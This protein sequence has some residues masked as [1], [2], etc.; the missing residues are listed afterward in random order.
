[1]DAYN[2]IS[3]LGIFVLVGVGWV[4]SAERRNMNRRVIGWGIGLQLLIGLFIFVV[5]A[6]A[7]AFDVVNVAVVEV[8]DS[9]SAG[10]KFVFGRL[11][12]GPGTGV[13]K[14]CG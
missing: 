14:S 3:F 8:L 10:A 9:A 11:A 4:L 1:M 7:K 5:P 13:R 6:G 12:L 2:L